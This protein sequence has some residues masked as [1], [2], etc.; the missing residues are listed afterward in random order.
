MANSK[1]FLIS[2]SALEDVHDEIS[3]L[4]A[5]NVLTFASRRSFFVALEII[6][7]SIFSLRESIFVFTESPNLETSLSVL[8]IL[9]GTLISI[10]EVYVSLLFL[11]IVFHTTEF[12]NELD[13]EMITT[14]ERSH[15]ANTLARFGK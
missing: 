5:D 12:Y 11:L 9:M 10:Q 1:K 7:I 14:L 15:N 6:V 2:I 3:S 13:A 8:T 4:T